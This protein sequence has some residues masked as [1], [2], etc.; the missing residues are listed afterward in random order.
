MAI[1]LS[2]GWD[3]GRILTRGPGSCLLGTRVWSL[4]IE[5]LFLSQGLDSRTIDET[6]SPSQ[7]LGIVCL[8][9]GLLFERYGLNLIVSYLDSD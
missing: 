9:V 5:M 3:N 8:F 6:R 1:G 7:G 4:S 2:L